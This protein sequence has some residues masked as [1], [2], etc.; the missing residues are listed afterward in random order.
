MEKEIVDVNGDGNCFYRALY[1][2]ILLNKNVHKNKSIVQLMN[3]LECQ[4]NQNKKSKIILKIKTEI[5][6]SYLEH[7]DQET[8]WVKCF[9][10]HMSK[11]IKVEP[12]IIKNNIEFWKNMDRETYKEAVR[13]YPMWFTQKFR[14]KSPN[15]KEYA[16][17]FAQNV[18]KLN[19]WATQLE[20]AIAKRVLYK[21]GINLKIESYDGNG[22]GTIKT[23]GEMESALELFADEPYDDTIYILNIGLQHFNFVYYKDVSPTSTSSRDNGKTPV[24]PLI[25]PTNGLK[26]GML[27]GGK[28]RFSRPKICINGKL[29]HCYIDK[30]N[31]NKKYIKMKNKKIYV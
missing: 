29:H 23:S 24:K 14:D 31:K 12:D 1:G 11:F 15:I 10:K 22:N 3:D 20:I 7:Y 17:L 21:Y 25:T 9:R 5:S 30:C 4:N 18:E 2:S 6:Q 26:S 13:T 16:E 27:V 8:E 19:T 28:K